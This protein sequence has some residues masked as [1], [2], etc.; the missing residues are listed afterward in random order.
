MKLIE[1]AGLR[2]AALPFCHLRLPV[3]V[4]GFEPSTPCA[5]GTC[6]AK[7]RHTLV[8]NGECRLPTAD[9][10]MKRSAW[11][12]I[13]SAFGNRPSAFTTLLP[14]GIEPIILRMKAGHPGHW[15]TGAAG[16]MPIVECRMKNRDL[17]IHP[18]F[19]IRQSAFPLTPTDGF[20]PPLTRLTDAR[21]TG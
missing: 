11:L 8:K 6:A 7:L 16:E 12:L 9:C 5:R 18:A 13:H 17:R 10:R 15:T 4:E 1:P 20:E 19:A 3:S 14:E 21:S 2:P